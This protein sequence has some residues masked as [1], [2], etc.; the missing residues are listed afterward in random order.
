M[1]HNDNHT[2]YFLAE[3][4][5]E[6]TYRL[7]FPDAK[8]GMAIIWLYE[9]MERGVFQQNSFKETDIHE[10]LRAVNPSIE[11][12]KSRH[13]KEHYNS[14][15][16]NLLEYFLRYDDE[17]RIYSFKEYAYDFCR[18]AHN[19]LKANFSPTQIEKIC[20]GLHEK[21]NR[22]EDLKLF[23]DWLKIDF[24]TFKPKLK[25]QLDFLDRQIDHSVTSLREN[26][27]LNLQEGAILETLRQID[28]RFE[29]IRNQNIELR[30]AFREIDQIRRLMESY[31]ATYENSEVDTL[32]HTA[33]TFFQEMRRTLGIIDK[34][35]DRIQ[36]KM[37]QL[38]SNLNKP[39]FNTRME[40]F[41]YHLIENCEEVTI[42][43]KKTIRLPSHI[44]RL[45]YFKLHQDFTIVE[46]KKDLFPLKAKKRLVIPES[47]EAKS[48]A[49]ASFQDKLQRQDEISRWIGIFKQ[50]V[51][52]S[53]HL[54]VSDYFFQ[55]A[56]PEDGLSLGLAIAVIYRS[57]A[58][59]E[60]QDQYTVNINLEKMVGD[61]EFKT[62]L[63]EIIISRKI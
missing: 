15:I 42:G 30:S 4:A 35:L 24:D 2:F 47:P 10:A 36:P 7:L 34:R 13:P 9:K 23:L 57:I 39:L 20:F 58:F 27:K 14:I 54:C 61:P 11:L 38:F 22:C 21:L 49:F 31:A 12:D 51:D 16:S 52:Q 5:K 62:S 17:R 25:S 40:R 48:K 55:I 28:E 6:N 32:V 60:R 37:R 8:A 3:I 19:I 44:P 53:S 59:F 43:T 63:W 33:I 56:R 26:K 18:Q 1:K 50:E 46:R 45:S 29:V 41:L